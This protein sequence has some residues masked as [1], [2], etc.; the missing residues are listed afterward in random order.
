MG[1]IKNT[2]LLIS[3]LLVTALCY[4]VDSSVTHADAPT[5]EQIRKD[6]FG[7]KR[8]T[9]IFG[10][11]SPTMT[12]PQCRRF[13]SVLTEADE[14]Y[15]GGTTLGVRVVNV[16]GG[17]SNVMNLPKIAIINDGI[18]S[19]HHSGNDILT[20]LDNKVRFTPKSEI[21]T[22]TFPTCDAVFSFAHILR[23]ANMYSI[24]FERLRCCEILQL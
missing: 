2:M 19:Q 12:T 21:E 10:H 4:I 9:V 7:K 22:F 14:R 16:L 18:E 13:Q 11:C 23:R 3:S 17:G 24:Y 1:R 5:Y 8:G 15:G 20:F 6:F